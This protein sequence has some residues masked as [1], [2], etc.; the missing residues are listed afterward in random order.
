MRRASGQ[1]LPAPRYSSTI[2]SYCVIVVANVAPDVDIIAVVALV[3]LRSIC[4]YTALAPQ[5]S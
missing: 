3:T 5:P 2:C 1:I 4:L